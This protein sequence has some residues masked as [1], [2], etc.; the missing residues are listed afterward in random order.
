L[1]QTPNTLGT[2]LGDNLTC[3]LAHNALSSMRFEEQWMRDNIK[4]IL[5]KK[6]DENADRI[7]LP[8]DKDKRE[9]VEITNKMQPCNRICYSK[10]Y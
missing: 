10:I 3:Q 5:E 6:K 9:S 7:Q 4:W 1:T 8:R 2:A